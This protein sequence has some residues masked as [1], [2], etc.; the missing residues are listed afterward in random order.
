[1]TLYLLPGFW[2]PEAWAG[3]RATAALSKGWCP[4]PRPCPAMWHRPEVG[5]GLLCYQGARHCSC[6]GTVSSEA[7]SLQSKARRLPQDQDTWT[8]ACLC[9]LPAVRPW[10]HHFPSLSLHF[11][12]SKRS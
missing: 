1:M 4:K 11:L 3:A 8:K 6:P 9:L 7:S 2:V 12:F 5:G 10:V